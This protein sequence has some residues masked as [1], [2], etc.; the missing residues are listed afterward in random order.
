VR[1]LTGPEQTVWAPLAPPSLALE[2]GR[3]SPTRYFY[4][5]P[6]TLAGLPDDAR[7]QKLAGILAELR[8]R[9]PALIVLPAS[10]PPRQ[11]LAPLVGEAV[12]GWVEESYRRLKAGPEDG[13]Q[14]FYV[15]RQAEAG[16]P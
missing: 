4:L 12:A 11:T 5:L 6:H 14:A 2:S 7:A 8:A 15:P 1:G 13:G 3:L 9:P 10:R 16:P